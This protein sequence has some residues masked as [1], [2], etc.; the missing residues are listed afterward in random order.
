MCGCW[1]RKGCNSFEHPY[2]SSLNKE[3]NF[4]FLMPSFVIGAIISICNWGN[5]GF[6]RLQNISKFT[7]LI[8]YRTGIKTEDTG[9]IG[10]TQPHIYLL[11][12]SINKCSIYCIN[13]LQRICNVRG[14]KNKLLIKCVVSDITETWKV[15]TTMLSS[16]P[17]GQKTPQAFRYSFIYRALVPASD[18]YCEDPETLAVT[19]SWSIQSLR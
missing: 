17:K 15:V 2:P 3:P 13:C 11:K 6:E 4:L 9:G 8:N 19:A 10:C 14:R 7:L 1:G 12:R 18:L 16:W 5:W